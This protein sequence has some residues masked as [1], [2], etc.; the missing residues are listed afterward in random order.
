MPGQWLSFETEIQVLEEALAL[1]G[2]MP[3]PY[4]EGRLLHVY[5]LLHIRQ[6][7]WARARARFEANLSLMP[8]H[9]A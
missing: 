4:C 2:S 3:W 7:Q 1:A 5:G 9:R 8:L 6:Q